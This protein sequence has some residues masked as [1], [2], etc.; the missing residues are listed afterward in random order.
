VLTFGFFMIMLDATIVQVALPRMEE[1]LNTGFDE[2][3]WVINAYTLAYAVLLIPAGRLGDMFGPK[4][5]F[6]AGLSLFTLA[7]AACGLSQTGGE[8]IAFRVAQAVGGALLTPQ[9]L[10]TIP[11]LAL[12]NTSW[13]FVIPFAVAGAG[14]GCTI[15]P[16]TTAAMRS[17]QPVMAGAAS[18]FINTVRQI[19]GALGTAVVGAVLANSVAADLPWQAARLVSQLPTPARAQYLATWQAA[20][21]HTQQFGA[22]QTLGLRPPPGVPQQ[23]LYQIEKIYRETF[24]LAFLTGV[25]SALWVVVFVI[26]LR[27]LISASFRGGRTAA[28]APE[29]AGATRV[30]APRPR[31]PSPTNQP[32][33]QPLP[34][35]NGMG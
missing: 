35:V 5:I 22:G 6:I 14:M 9:T 4:R 24:D 11:T 10:L 12:D 2:V 29:P 31:E 26:G 32:A 1:A 3:L 17:V 27:L 28:E 21:H 7:S 20:S 25:R 19:G 15:V 18:G 16:T 8:L 30:R 13:S 34:H 33:N 23:I